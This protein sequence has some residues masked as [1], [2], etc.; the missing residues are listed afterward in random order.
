MKKAFKLL[1]IYSAKITT[2]SDTS[3]LPNAKSQFTLLLYYLMLLYLNTAA[4]A[5]VP[6]ICWAFFGN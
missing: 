4:R 5:A 3:S 1:N 6:K 2:G